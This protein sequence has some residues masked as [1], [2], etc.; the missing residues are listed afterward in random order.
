MP[1]DSRK[2]GK[3]N[4]IPPK[5]QVVG[6][7]MFDAFK[8]AGTQWFAHKSPKAGASL[9]YYSVFSMG[10]LIIVVI[11]IAALVFQRE[12]V[13][14]QVVDAIKGVIGDKGAEAVGAMLGGAGSTGQ[15]VFATIVGTATLMFAAIGVIV[16]LKE[17]LN[18]VWEVEAER[19]S[20]LW[21]FVREYLLSFAGVLALGFLLM[22]S[23]LLSA[24]LAATGKYLG[25]ALSEPLMQA[26][27]FAISFLTTT[28]MF[29]LLFKWMPDANVEWRDVILGAFGTAALFEIG[30]FIIS[31]YIGKQGLDSTY[32]ASASIV[33]VLIWVYY[34]AQILLF[35]AEFTHARFR[36]RQSQKARPSSLD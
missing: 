9:A 18:T 8:R 22:I 29:A 16:Q 36:Q 27:S 12:G 33:I 14:R 19:Q 21:A 30:K 20:G 15:G 26:L 17:A 23:M 1:L 4:A 35:G 13:E 6:P 11:S 10:P 2:P 24:G 28:A 7:G 5:D 25:S 31:Y 34:S 3:P 32:G